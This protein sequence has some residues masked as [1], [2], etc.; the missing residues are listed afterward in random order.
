MVGVVENVWG[1]GVVQEAQQP[2]TEEVGVGVVGPGESKFGDSDGDRTPIKP[3]QMFALRTP[4]AISDINSSGSDSDIQSN[5]NS[6]LPPCKI[7]SWET[8]D[9]PAWGKNK[10]FCGKMCAMCLV[11]SMSGRQVKGVP[12]YWIGHTTPA[13][14]CQ[15][16][17]FVLCDP[18]RNK[19]IHEMTPTRASRH[20][21]KN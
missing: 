16:C 18:C 17:R 13:Y 2:T 9:L 8:F 4:P 6:N 12:G 14:A 1:A 7:H 3:P 15:V 11:P 20:R 10:K 5:S 21:D 19:T